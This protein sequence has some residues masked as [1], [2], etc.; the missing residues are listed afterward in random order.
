MTSLSVSAARAGVRRRY[1][2]YVLPL[3]YLAPDIV[4]A[5]AADR[6]PAELTAQTL[7]KRV[8]LPFDW[9]AQKRMLGI[10]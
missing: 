2:S 9:A 8:V 7:I 5:I 10:G 6:Q 3:A 4:E 1:V